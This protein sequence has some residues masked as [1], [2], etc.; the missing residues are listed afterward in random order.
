MKRNYS[1]LIGNQFA[2][3][4]GPNQTSFKPGLIPWNKGKRG[5]CAEGCRATQFKKGVR[6]NKYQPIGTVSIRKDKKGNRRRYIK[7]RDD[8]RIQDNWKMYSTWLWEK[9]RGP[10]PIG[11][12]I[13]HMDEDT[14][15]DSISNFALVT[16]AAHIRIHH[17]KLTAAKAL[18]FQ[19]RAARRLSQEVLSL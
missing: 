9:E 6:G 16:R 11:L 7:V 12:F 19:R 10:I 3:G 5:W 1:H 17:S 15:N 2:K 4:N 18:A 13:H 14:L 8:G